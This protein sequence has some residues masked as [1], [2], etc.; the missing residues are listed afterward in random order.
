MLTKRQALTIFSW[1]GDSG[2]IVTEDGEYPAWSNVVGHLLSVSST[3]GIIGWIVYE[4]VWNVLYKGE[5]IDH[6]SSRLFGTIP[7]SF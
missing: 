2:T 6:A 4:I 5:V 1:Y 7:P 3:L